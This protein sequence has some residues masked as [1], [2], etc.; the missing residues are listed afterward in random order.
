MWHT[1]LEEVLKQTITSTKEL[2]NYATQLEAK[3]N[4]LAKLKAEQNQDEYIAGMVQKAQQIGGQQLYVAPHNRN[5][6]GYAETQGSIPNNQW[7]TQHPSE[8]N[9][10]WTTQQPSE[11][12]NRCY[13]CGTHGHIAR[14]CSSYHQ[15]NSQGE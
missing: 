15:K 9:N 13:R 14:D 11:W 7:T 5:M 8:W 1:T 10:Q 3:Q 6:R 2:K 4:L 12:Y